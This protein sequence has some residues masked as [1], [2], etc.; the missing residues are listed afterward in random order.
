[1]QEDFKQRL[2]RKGF[3]DVDIPERHFEIG[4]T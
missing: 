4:L 2:I 1:V 3:V